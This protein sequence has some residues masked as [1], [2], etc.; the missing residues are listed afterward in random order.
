MKNVV[1]DTRVGMTALHSRS[2]AFAQSA[3]RLREGPK[4]Q[5]W[6]DSDLIADFQQS[7]VAIRS[8][9]KIHAHDIRRASR[10]R[11]DAFDPDLRDEVHVALCLFQAL[12]AASLILGEPFRK[13][14][15]T[16]NHEAEIGNSVFQI[17]RL[18]AR[19]RS[20]EHTSEL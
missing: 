8:F 7:V 17:R 16:F 13:T 3:Q 9:L 1:K 12:G 6:H 11:G 14:D 4:F 20:E 19:V 10:W 2:D 18:A 5:F 15:C